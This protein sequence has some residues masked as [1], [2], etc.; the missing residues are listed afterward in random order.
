[1]REN[2][3]KNSLTQRRKGAEI[4]LARPHPDL[5]PGEGTA[6]VRFRIFSAIPLS[7]FFVLASENLRFAK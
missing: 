2:Y 4:I 7:P 6:F 3:T 5:P 1:M